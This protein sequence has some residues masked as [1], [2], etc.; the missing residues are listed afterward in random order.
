[1]PETDWIEEGS[2]EAE[3]L[4]IEQ[5]D[6]TA[7]PNDFNILTIQSFLESGAVCAGSA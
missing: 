4:E 6:L 7:T 3:E 2:E 1:M 5:Y